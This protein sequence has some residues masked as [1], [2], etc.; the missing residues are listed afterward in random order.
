MNE[1]EI[2]DRKFLR[3]Q[4]LESFVSKE[5]RSRFVCIQIYLYSNLRFRGYFTPSEGIFYQMQDR[6]CLFLDFF[7]STIHLLFRKC[8][9][10]N[11][12]ATLDRV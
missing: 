4:I 2:V 10:S 8:I 11:P 3:F 6:V 1:P 7:L 5:E 9:H 12:I